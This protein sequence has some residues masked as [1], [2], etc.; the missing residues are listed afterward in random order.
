MKDNVFMINIPEEVKRT[1]DDL[2]IISVITP[3]AEE[4]MK[5]RGWETIACD[6]HTNSNSLPSRA[7]THASSDATPLS[8]LDRPAPSRPTFPTKEQCDGTL[9]DTY[10]GFGMNTAAGIVMAFEDKVVFEECVYSPLRLWN[11]DLINNKLATKDK[12]KLPALCKAY[13]AIRFLHR[14]EPPKTMENANYTTLKN[15][16]NSRQ[17]EFIDEFGPEWAT[18]GKG[19]STLPQKA[20]MVYER[21]VN[22]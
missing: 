1:Y 6:H 2:K 16:Y 17:A 8:L 5:T 20:C 11:A 12:S 18:K 19:K 14:L 10:S 9:P 4:V 7:P 13:M 3:R 15:E 22:N 21:M